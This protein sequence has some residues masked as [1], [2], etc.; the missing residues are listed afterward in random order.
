MNVGRITEDSIRIADD[1]I[2]RK[3]PT[4]GLCKRCFKVISRNKDDYCATC[5]KK[6]LGI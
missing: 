2:I 6:E 3:V 4:K 5:Y 1:R